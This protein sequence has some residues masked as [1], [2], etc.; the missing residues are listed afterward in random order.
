MS[1]SRPRPRTPEHENLADAL[2]DGRIGGAR[3]LVA[4]RLTHL[5]VEAANPHLD[6]FVRRQRPVGLC[7]HRCGDARVADVNDRFEGMGS[8]L[9]G[10]TLSCSQADRHVCIVVRRLDLHLGAQLHHPPR[11]QVIEPRR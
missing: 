7:D 9:E 3:Q 2:H 1:G 6:Q 4:Q 5:A 8:R 10:R 11:R